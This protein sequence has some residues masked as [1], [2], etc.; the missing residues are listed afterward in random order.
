MPVADGLCP[1]EMGGLRY[2]YRA[3]RT[4]DT[5]PEFIALGE[6]ADRMVLL[7]QT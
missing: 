4:R 2:T 1:L 6:I 3:V 7:V 5:D